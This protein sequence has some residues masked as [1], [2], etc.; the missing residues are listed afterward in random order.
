MSRANRLEKLKPSLASNCCDAILVSQPENRRYLSG[1]TGSAGNLLITEKEQIL[2]TDFRYLEQ[3]E[4][5]SPQY[6]LFR[7]A[8]EMMT[9]FPSM[10]A[11]LEIARLGYEAE[12]LTWAAHQRLEAVAKPL[13]IEMVP[14]TGVI[15][16]IRALKEA[17]EIARIKKA[18]AISDRALE[19]ACRIIAAG[20]TELQLAWEIEKF[21][22][23]EGSQT[24]P[25]EVIVAAGPNA[26]L[27]HAQPS[28]RPIEPGEPVVI[29]IGARVNGY[30]SDLTR[31]IGIGPREGRFEEIYGVVLEAQRT[32]ENE[33]RRGMTGEAADRLARNIIERAGYASHFGHGLGHGLG[34]VA[35]EFPRLGS[36]SCDVL[37]NDM[38]FTLEP[39]IYLPGWG[40]VRIEDTVLLRDGKIEILSRAGK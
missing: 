1:F 15:E 13:G 5:E 27:P 18:V 28:P 31:T 29:D 23:E 11:G 3:A 6:T 7:I 14:V 10:L 22:R 37:D 20:M 25:F 36:G 9:W 4:R 32:A 38:V 24:L 16:R 12:H 35:H 19:H 34:L 2:A 40:G 21:M 8:G 39:G 30:V 26:A 17:G 33:I